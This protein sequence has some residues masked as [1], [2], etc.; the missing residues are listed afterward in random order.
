MGTELQ[1][2]VQDILKD[3]EKKFPYAV[4][5]IFSNRGS[6]I[7]LE[8]KEERLSSTRSKLG[9]VLSV[10]N[11]EYFEEFATDKLEKDHIVEFCR[12]AIDGIATKDTKYEIMSDVPMEAQAAFLFARRHLMPIQKAAVYMTQNPHMNFIICR[13]VSKSVAPT[14]PPITTRKPINRPTFT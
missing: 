2:L 13:M 4:A 14:A 3:A 9:F 12:S 1:T 5:S 7:N 10:F 11:G 8:K 6:E